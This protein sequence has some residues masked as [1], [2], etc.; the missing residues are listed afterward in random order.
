MGSCVKLLETLSQHRF[1]AF[2]LLS[3]CKFSIVT[4]LPKT[5]DNGGGHAALH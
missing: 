5:Q 4:S 2:E 1:Q 3:G